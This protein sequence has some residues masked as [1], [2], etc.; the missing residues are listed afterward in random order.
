MAAKYFN[1]YGNH[2][3]SLVFFGTLLALNSCATSK[4]EVG[5]GYYL[6]AAGGQMA[7]F[8]RARPISEI[9]DSKDTAPKTKRLLLEVAKI[10]SY[11]EQ[12]GIKPTRSYETFV[13][14][15]HPAVSY[16]V[17]ASKAT[18]FEAK[19][20]SF[21]FVGSFE[22]LGW[23]DPE[24]AKKFARELDELGWDTEV[25]GAQAYS[26]VGYFNDPVLSTMLWDGD[27]AMGALVNTI[28]HE[29]VHATIYIKNQ[30]SFDE[31]LA[32]F[33]AD[34]LAPLYLKERFGAD[35]VELKSYVENQ[36]QYDSRVKLYNETYLKL[37]SIYQ[38]K[39][40]EEEK[41]QKKSEILSELKQKLKTDRVLNNASL[42]QYKVYHRAGSEFESLYEKLGKDLK[43]TLECLKKVDAGSF[44]ESQ[45]TDFGPVIMTL[46]K[47]CL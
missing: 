38:S 31:S 3:R 24:E 40:S 36:N 46:T 41:L 28:L 10:K 16:V 15:H 33:I 43:K 44:G 1:E 37:D 22:Y 18:Q 34:H 20:W 35:S 12:F 30:T 5:M 11:A 42:Y 27:E 14:W 13:K 9:I 23:F 47:I 6:Q 26:T 8:N 7:I 45:Q 39:I 32:S 2:L 25:R 29:S 4:G 17:T 21:P 19:K